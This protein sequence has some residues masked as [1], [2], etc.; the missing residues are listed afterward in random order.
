MFKARKHSGLISSPRDFNVDIP[1]IEVDKNG[2]RLQRV[3]NVPISSIENNVPSPDEYR[4]SDLLAA[5]VP[6]QP[7]S[8]N[9]LD[10]SPSESEVNSFLDKLEKSDEPSKE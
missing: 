10:S 6:L 8:A 1:V 5:G 7:V 2:T 9:I 4:L 3:V